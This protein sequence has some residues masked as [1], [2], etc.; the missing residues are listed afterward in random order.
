[1]LCALGKSPAP[2]GHMGG[3]VHIRTES[4]PKAWMWGFSF[5]ERCGYFLNRLNP[6]TPRHPPGSRLPDLNLN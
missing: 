3:F 5:W 2:S 4:Q 6:V 1:M